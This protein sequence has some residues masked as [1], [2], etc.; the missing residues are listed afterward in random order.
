MMEA[1]YEVLGDAQSDAASEE[2]ID[3]INGEEVRAHVEAMSMG[4]KVRAGISTLGFAMAVLGIWG[5]GAPADTYCVHRS[6]LH[7][8]YSVQCHFDQHARSL[9]ERMGSLRY[10]QSFLSQEDKNHESFFV[11]QHKQES[12]EFDEILR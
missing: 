2:E 3:D 1:S 12:T 5:D 4:Y 6:Q 7:I 10:C 8:F 9:Y 11:L